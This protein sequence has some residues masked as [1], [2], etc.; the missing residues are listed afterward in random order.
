VHKAFSPVIN[1]ISNSLLFS[2]V[3]SERSSPFIINLPVSS[4]FVVL[5]DVALNTG[6]SFFLNSSEV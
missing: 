1:I 6:I 5:I 2:E 3:Y 4:E